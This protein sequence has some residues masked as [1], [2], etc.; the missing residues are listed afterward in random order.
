MSRIPYGC[1]LT[2][3]SNLHNGYCLLSYRFDSIY[4]VEIN[5]DLVFVYNL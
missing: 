5:G 1:G 2:P 4:A 3:K